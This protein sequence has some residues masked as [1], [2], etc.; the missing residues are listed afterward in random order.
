MSLWAHLVSF[1]FR[2]SLFTPR[3]SFFWNRR[4]MFGMHTQKQ[5]FP[6][7]F[8]FF[9][10][11]TEKQLFSFLRF[12]QEHVSHKQFFGTALPSPH[13]K[14]LRS[15]L[16]HVP[17]KHNHFKRTVPALVL[18][19]ACFRGGTSKWQK[20]IHHLIKISDKNLFQSIFTQ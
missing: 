14:Q 10:L 7:G 15:S 18:Y 9:S 19:R 1:L 4:T 12:F 6:L 17:K 3:T 11:E 20:N 8:F 5:F 13:T 2:F 16:F